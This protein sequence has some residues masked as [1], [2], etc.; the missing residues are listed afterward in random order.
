MSSLS[1]VPDITVV[2]PV[3]ILN[4]IS[5]GLLAINN[6]RFSLALKHKRR[7]LLRMRPMVGTSSVPMTPP[8]GMYHQQFRRR[9]RTAPRAQQAIL[10]NLSSLFQLDNSLPDLYL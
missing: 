9:L 2:A 4:F 10:A 3:I 5:L 6:L 1:S 8:T 7:K